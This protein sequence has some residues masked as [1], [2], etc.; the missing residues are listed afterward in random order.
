MANLITSH[1]DSL[2]FGENGTPQHAWSNSKTPFQ[3]SLVALDFQCVRQVKC[4]DTAISLPVKAISLPVK[5]ISLPVKAYADLVT[6]NYHDIQKANYLIS[7]LARVRDID[8]TGKGEYALFHDMILAWD[9]CHD[10]DHCVD[11]V[12]M[13]LTGTLTDSFSAQ[14]Y[15]SWKD[16]KYILNAWK[17]L[18]GVARWESSLVVRSIVELVTASLMDDSSSVMLCKWLPREKSRKFGWQATI[19]ASQIFPDCSDKAALTRYRKLIASTNVASNTTQVLQCDGRWS[20]IDFSKDVTSITMH[21]QRHAFACN[22]SNTDA[23]NADRRKCAVNYNAYI[24]SC[25]SGDSAYK[26]SRLGLDVLCR[27]F[28][29]GSNNKDGLSSN[30]RRLLDLAWAQQNQET[31]G[32]V[33]NWVTMLDTSTSMEWENCPL[34]A[35]MGLALRIAEQSILGP[36]VMTFAT[37]PSWINLSTASTFCERMSIIMDRR[38]LSGTSTNFASALELIAE[39]CV[40]RQLTPSEVESLVLC[41]LSDMQIDNADTSFAGTMDARIKK[42]FTEAGLRS[43]HAEPYPAPTIVYWNMRTTCGMPCATDAQGVITTSGYSPSILTHFAA[44]DTSKL[45]SMTPWTHL[46]QQLNSSRYT[47]LWS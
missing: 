46:E 42:T 15:G 24:A 10:A 3:D 25:L 18:N 23:H 8:G 31:V 6:S 29:R 9:N 26:S 28:V 7:F 33:S 30:E 39:A 34:Y 21:R 11:L 35:A 43:M 16:A 32:T 44:G 41:I 22:G 38:A 14:G 27:D 13:L 45:R 1:L 12:R 5:A 36:R 40:A 37:R 4:L 17:R 19:F 47:V 20:D 2:S